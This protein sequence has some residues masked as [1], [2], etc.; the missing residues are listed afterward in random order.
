MAS[1][2]VLFLTGHPPF[3]ATSGGYQRSNLLLRALRQIGYQTDL[4]LLAYQGQDLPNLRHMRDHFGLTDVIRVPHRGQRGLW[5][6]ARALS[7]GKTDRIAHNFGRA[8]VSYSAAASTIAQL[9]KVHAE[10]RYAFG[11]CRYLKTAGMS[12]LDQLMPTFTDID[13]LDWMSYSAR[14]A[15]GSDSRLARMLVRRHEQQLI[16]VVPNVA[17][18]MAGL[19]VSN[20]NDLVELQHPNMGCLPNIPFFEGDQDLEPGRVAAPV[21]SK[22]IVFV[23]SYLHQPNVVAAEYLVREVM[24]MLIRRVSGAELRLVGSNMSDELRKKW[25]G[26]AGVVPV[27]SVPS[28]HEE[29]SRAAVVAVPIFGGAGTNLK[30]VEAMKAGRAC[31]VTPF[32]MRGIESWAKPDEHL[33]VGRDAAGFVEQLVRVLGDS[34]LRER[35]GSL[36]SEAAKRELSYAR[37][38]SLVDEVIVRGVAGK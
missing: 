34:A 31:V 9:S 19:W 24:P 26:H 11:V 16:Q 13:D 6:F 35:L 28:V 22:T 38:V 2:R 1:N 25:T 4:L 30:L 10:R 20:K 15:S 32:A 27:G 33:L 5:K 14:L 17:S 18:R 36:A 21:E 3:P 29:Y 12:G 8:S 23:G 7:P 37:F